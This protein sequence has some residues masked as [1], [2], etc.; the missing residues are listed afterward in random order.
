MRRF[1]KP[2]CIY[3][4]CLITV[5]LPVYAIDWQDEDMTAE[6]YDFNL[7]TPND[8][9]RHK[10]YISKHGYRREGT[11]M[12]FGASNEP[13]HLIINFDTATCWLTRPKK[14]LY[15]SLELLPGQKDCEYMYSPFIDPDYRYKLWD[16]MACQGY[17]LKERV[18]S[19]TLN[20]TPTEKWACGDSSKKFAVLQWF[21]PKMKLV[22]REG[23]RDGDIFELRNIK[24]SPH[25]SEVF[26]QPRGYRKRDREQF[27][28]PSPLP[29]P[30][31]Q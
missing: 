25:S 1:I 27:F 7:Y 8:V 26:L 18:G 16:R 11:F 10:V 3:T 29:V 23:T 14:R 9:N 5:G 31:S 24:R 13:L 22:I 17:D 20:G 6:Q 28:P 21:D 19:E 4:F 30:L 12:V 2:V 15:T